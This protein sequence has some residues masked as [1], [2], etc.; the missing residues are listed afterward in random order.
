MADVDSK[1]EYAPGVTLYYQ[2]DDCDR[3]VGKA[4]ALVASGLVQRNWLP[5]EE[6]NGKTAQSLIFLEDGSAQLL[7]PKSHFKS[8]DRGFGGIKIR[9][10]GSLFDVIKRCGKAEAERRKTASD[11]EK[12]KEAWQLAKQVH[13]QPDLPARWKSGVLYHIDQAE[14]LIEGRLVFTDFPDI[15]IQASDVESAKKAIAELRDILRWA[16]PKIKDK[17]QRSNVVSLND[18][19]FRFMKRS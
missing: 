9:A 6:G 4:T 3:Y 5:G 13:S 1:Q 19:A 7:K 15:G 17:V 2:C 8:F 10:S 14:R 16:T 18:A 12:E 11:A